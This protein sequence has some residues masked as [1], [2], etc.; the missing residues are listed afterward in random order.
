MQ[1]ARVLI[2]VPKLKIIRPL[3]CKSILWGNSVSKKATLLKSLILGSALTPFIFSM[4]H[5]NILN[6]GFENGLTGWTVSNY[7]SANPVAVTSGSTTTAAGTINPSLTGDN[8]VYT[9]QTGQGASYLYQN[10][11]VGSGTNKVFFDVAINNAGFSGYVTPDS[12][13]PTAGPNQQA[14]FDILKPGSAF[15]TIDANDIIVNAY[16]TEVGDPAV[17]NWSTVEVDVTNDLQAY[18]G[19]QVIFRFVQVDNSGYFNLALDNINVGASQF[20]LVPSG[21]F[22]PA[23]P[24]NTTLGTA[25]TLDDILASGDTLPADFDAALTTLSALS[26]EDKAAALQKLTPNTSATMSN[27][28]SQVLQGGLNEIGGRINAVHTYN[29][30][31]VS[32]GDETSLL[33]SLTDPNS[34]WGQ[35][36]AYKSDQGMEDGFAGYEGISRSMLVGYDVSPVDELIMGM[37]FGYTDT[38]ID[39]KDFRSG[40]DAEI[41]SYQL[42]LYGSYQFE[43]KLVFDLFGSYA[44]HEFEGSR[45]TGIDTAD[46]DFGA[47]H[48][49]LRFDVSREFP[50]GST[51][52]SILPKA[53][54]EATTLR[55]ES[56][57]E[58]GS[59][60]GQDFDSET[61]NRLRSNVSVEFKRPVVFED[62]TTVVPKLRV[63][64][65]HEFRDDGMNSTSRF[66]G[67][68]SEFTT[69]GQS[70]ERNT[71]NLRA[72]VDIFSQKNFQV[73]AALEGDLADEYQG[74]G[75]QLKLK[76][77]F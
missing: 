62:Q 29:N 2:S 15:D 13:D 3:I 57:T 72:G 8:Y 44:R 46:A 67:G 17:Q 73:E 61:S 32:S 37:A 12:L 50:V 52:I 6:G 64:W 76:W 23:S 41:D 31:G 22:L 28:T 49:G 58:T 54:M 39:M 66:V 45:S 68:G 26:D 71:L 24:N 34:F 55:Q 16:R 69:P 7:Y 77:G 42:S 9:S 65:K 53:G 19:Q 5:A 38:D 35:V 70:V 60:L 56:Y 14:R 27:V 47:N 20:V 43:N 74:Y 25:Q 63:G 33:G 4:A 1:P 10:F 75:A 59:A 40:D 30:T 36:S 11:T 21:V 51:G 18:A 48:Y